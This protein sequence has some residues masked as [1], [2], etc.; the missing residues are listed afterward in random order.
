MM[1]AIYSK[2]M[3]FSKGPLNV[4]FSVTFQGPKQKVST[5]LLHN[6]V[7]SSS[8]HPFI[9]GGKFE[10]QSIN[11]RSISIKFITEEGDRSKL[12]CKIY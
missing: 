3:S 8:G 2:L 9:I 4:T 6:K 1:M 7:A 11:K 5:Y 12:G 10:T